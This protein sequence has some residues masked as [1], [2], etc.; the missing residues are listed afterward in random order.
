[1]PFRHL[2]R[3]GGIPN[4]VQ[5][6]YN[7]FF[8]QITRGMK[9]TFKKFYTSLSDDPVKQNKFFGFLKIIGCDVEKKLAKRF[10]NG[11]DE[12]TKCNFDVEITTD[13]CELVWKRE[14]DE[15]ILASGDS[16]FNYVLEKAKRLGFGITIISSNNSLS[17]ELR[18]VADVL[19]LLED[20]DLKD[21]SRSK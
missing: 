8:K 20:F 13:I 14:C 21:I 9:V 15:I 6:D 3:P 7:L 18:G 1:M 12:K 17:K 5:L 10:K 19:L 16:D 2:K 4:N 11:D